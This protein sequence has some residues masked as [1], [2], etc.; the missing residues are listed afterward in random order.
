MCL[1]PVDNNCSVAATVSKNKDKVYVGE[2]M[3]KVTASATCLVFEPT[4]S[5]RILFMSSNADDTTP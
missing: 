3:A 1:L 2:T 4:P 5:R